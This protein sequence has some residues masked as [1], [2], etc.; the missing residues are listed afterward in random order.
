[1]HQPDDAI[2]G[3][4]ALSRFEVREGFEDKVAAAFQARPRLVDAVE[5][6]LRLDVL[7]PTERPHE[8]WLLTYWTDES[9]FQQWHH[10]HLRKASHAYLPEGLRLVPG[11]ARIDNLEHVAS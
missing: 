5:G 10:S 9:S 7:R 6:F 11:S 2:A 3:H 1:M 4:V 8:F